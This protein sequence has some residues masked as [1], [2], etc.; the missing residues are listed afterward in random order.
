MKK[1]GIGIVVLIGC[2]LVACAMGKSKEKKDM[3][4]TTKTEIATEDETMT[5]A[6]V[7]TTTEEEYTEAPH[8]T[9]DW[10]VHKPA[11]TSPDTGAPIE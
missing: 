5:E 11:D 4:E 1:I 9:S 6:P 7:E 8:D 10:E 2:F 3:K